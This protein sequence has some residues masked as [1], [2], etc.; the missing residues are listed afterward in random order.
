MLKLLSTKDLIIPI[1][2]EG[3]T[4]E[5]SHHPV[6][7][8]SRHFLEFAGWQKVSKHVNFS[9]QTKRKKGRDFCLFFLFSS[10]PYFNAVW[11]TLPR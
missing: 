5:A 7:G 1:V 8:M 3:N 2:S 9:L 11:L 6:V 4:P 10:D